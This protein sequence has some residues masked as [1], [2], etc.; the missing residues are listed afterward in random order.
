MLEYFRTRWGSIR[1]T[2]I[3]SPT[4]QLRSW[5][6][7]RTWAD[8]LGGVHADLINRSTMTRPATPAW[9]RSRHRAAAAHRRTARPRCWVFH[10]SLKLSYTAW[11]VRSTLRISST[12]PAGMPAIYYVQL[13]LDAY[14]R[15]AVATTGG[16][17]W[18]P[19]WTSRRARAIATRTRGAQNDGLRPRSRPTTR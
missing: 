5:A 11:R 8:R 6:P 1:N 3:T 12:T 17:P 18:K 4:G 15:T 14:D 2:A 13:D 19:W 10:A 16:R 7:G 9:R